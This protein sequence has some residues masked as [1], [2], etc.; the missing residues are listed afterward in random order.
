MTIQFNPAVHFF[1]IELKKKEDFSRTGQRFQ[2]RMDQ[3]PRVRPISG[4]PEKLS[5][6]W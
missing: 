6:L 4:V 1:Q 5:F 3:K 2:R